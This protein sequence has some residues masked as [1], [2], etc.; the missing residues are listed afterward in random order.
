MIKKISTFALA[1][2]CALIGGIAPAHAVT[3]TPIATI[4][5]ELTTLSGPWGVT[6]DSNGT[7]FVANEG[8]NTVLV[9]DAEADGNVAPIAE[10]Q[11]ADGDFEDLYDVE[12]DV[13][14]NIYVTNSRGVS[15]FAP[16]ADGT[17]TPI[18]EIT[19]FGGYGVAVGGDGTVYVSLHENDGL[20]GDAGDVY[21][22][23]P[24][25]DGEATPVKVL[26]GDGD[27]VDVAVDN[28]GNVYLSNYGN[29]SID[30]WPADAESGDE[31]TRVI[32][33][34]STDIGSNYGIDVDCADGTIVIA[35]QDPEKVLEFQSTDDGD[36]VPTSAI[37]ESIESYGLGFGLAGGL[38]VS[39]N[40]NNGTI[41]VFD[42]DTQCQPTASGLADTGFDANN[43]GL[44]AA[45]L[46]AAG[47]VALAMRR[48]KG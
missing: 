23:A 2:S 7:I 30:F 46:V 15:I 28:E 31:P 39:S 42:Y 22:F 11:R 26:D 14:G 13:D 34:E 12:V 20:D 44:T 1:L 40:A 19:G 32:T 17:V 21:V 18:R 16:G 27:S 9:F 36:A 47:G 6:A 4:S 25:A 29:D 48:R 35:S 24:D 3:L 45:G 38:Y 43:V 37:Y 5:G 41:L 10:I 33:G 8:S